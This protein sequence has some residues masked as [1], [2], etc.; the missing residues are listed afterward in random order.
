MWHLNYCFLNDQQVA[1]L[2]IFGCKHTSTTFFSC[3]HLHSLYV[4]YDEIGLEQ[5]IQIVFIT[6][7]FSIVTSLLS[8]QLLEEVV[9]LVSELDLLRARQTL[10]K[11]E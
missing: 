11:S 7:Y 8:L 2:Q 5:L 6:C 3:P 10:L 9:D 4:I 1:T